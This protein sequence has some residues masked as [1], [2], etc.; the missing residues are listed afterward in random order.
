MEISQ[1]TP[2]VQLVCA[3]KKREEKSKGESPRL[4]GCFH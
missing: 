1:Q 4:E 3:D 2:F